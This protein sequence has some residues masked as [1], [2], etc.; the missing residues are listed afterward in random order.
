[1]TSRT[2]PRV[3]CAI[4]TRKSSEEGL[5]QDFNSLHAQ[6]EACAAY[7]RSQAG[8]GWTLLPRDY[9][10]GGISGGTLERPAL[11]RLL[12]DIAAGHIDIVVVYKVDRLTR[13][14]LD[15]AKLVETFDRCEV[16]FVSVTQSF[17]TTTSMGR[18]TLNMLLSFAQFEREVTA[19]RIRDK[20]AASKARGMWMGGI[21]PL[22]YRPNGRSLAIVEEHAVLVRQI[23]ERYLEL[24]CVRLLADELKAS[25]VRAPQRTTTKGKAYGG[26][27]LSRGQLYFILKNPVYAGDIPHKDKV[28]PGHHEAIVSR[29]TWQR[30][31]ELLATNRRGSRSGA[32]VPS[33]ALLAGRIV[34]AD[35]EPMA[36]THTAKNKVRYRYYVSRA[37][38]HR[39]ASEGIR[40]PGREIEALVK[41][42]SAQLYSDPWRLL[43]QLGL[44]PSPALLRQLDERCGA[45]SSQLRSRTGGP[46]RELLR[47]VRVHSDR[48]E[49]TLDGRSVARSIGAGELGSDQHTLLLVAPYRLTR[50]GSTLRLVQSDGAHITSAP[51]TALARMIILA[52][53][54]WAGLADGATDITTLA[55]QA[56]YTPSSVTRVLRLAFLSPRVVE[57]VLGGKQHSRLSAAIV[58]S[59]VELPAA[60][61]DQEAMFLVD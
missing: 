45:L 20:I 49:I 17:N 33:E 15:F 42:T 12:A 24:G 58:R 4:Y 3:R 50:S 21:P 10:D 28:Y 18:L 9:D 14:L 6:R 55:R 26:G 23:Y 25:S 8:E 34:D 60:W 59:S 51:D 1:M 41:E 36:T 29:E 56:G 61:A 47:E 54:W 30:V 43:A 57:A 11:K 52:R 22:G 2:C 16:S 27:I 37:L 19:E 7:V 53:Q 13:S 31:Q 40:V 44:D 5:E 48:L 39:R 38:H 35:G 46:L 32:H